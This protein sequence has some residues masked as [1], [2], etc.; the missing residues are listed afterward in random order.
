VA[1]NPPPKAPFTDYRFEKPGKIFARSRLKICPLPSHGLV[2]QWSSTS[3]HVLANAWPQV[4]PGF[5]VEL[6]ASGLNDPRLIRTALMV[7]SL[8]PRATPTISAFSEG[9]PL[10]VSLNNQK[11]SSL[12]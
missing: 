6:Y 2:R 7:I 1:R 5:K 10:M 11:P 9:S 12:D 8:L 4:L 3:C